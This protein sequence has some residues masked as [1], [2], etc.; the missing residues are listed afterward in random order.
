MSRHTTVFLDTPGDCQWLRETHL[1]HV[2]DLPDFGSAEVWGNEDC[3][4]RV[5]LYSLQSPSIHDAPIRSFTYD[6]ECGRLL[7]CTAQQEA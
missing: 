3:P 6:T 2:A 5:N 4:D 1:K 7:D